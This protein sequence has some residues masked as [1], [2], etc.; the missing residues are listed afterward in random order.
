MAY[1]LLSRRVP[2][3]R[4]DSGALGGAALFGAFH[5]TL[6]PALGIQAPVGELPRA[7]WVWEGGSHVVFGVAVDLVVG[8][9]RRVTG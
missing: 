5:G 3:L 4:T 2:P 1:S 6:L 9:V 7:W 8:G